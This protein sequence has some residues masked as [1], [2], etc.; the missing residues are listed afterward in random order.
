M[1]GRRVLLV[2][3]DRTFCEVLARSLAR[4]GY[5]VVVA[6]GGADATAMAGSGEFS[7]ILLDLMLGE[8]SGLHL[9]EPLRAACPAARIVV[10]TGY[11]SIPTTVRALKLGAADYLAKPV[12]SREVLAAM[13][14]EAPAAAPAERPISLRRLE[15]EHIQRVL[16][17]HDGNVSLAAK[18]LNMHRRSLQRKLRKR[19]PRD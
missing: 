19:A 10:L 1:S 7:H 2:D 15:W 16:A 6:H 3:D 5:V 8:E 11:A 12:G 9:I 14:G 17:D 18:S 13:A 4:N